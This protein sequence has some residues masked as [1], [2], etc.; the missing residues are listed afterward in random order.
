MVWYKNPKDHS[1]SHPWPENVIASGPDVLF[2]F[3]KV[4]VSGSLREVIVTAEYFHPRIRI[5]WTKSTEQDWSK[6][7]L[8][9]CATSCSVVSY[10]KLHHIAFYISCLELVLLLHTD[11]YYIPCFCSNTW[12][13]AYSSY[14]LLGNQNKFIS[15]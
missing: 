3:T 12:Q 13:S 15:A 11:A 8:V 2:A 10:F 5:F 9:S 7:A 4:N 1:L 14:T 6:T